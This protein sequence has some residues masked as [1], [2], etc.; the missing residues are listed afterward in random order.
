MTRENIT[1]APLNIHGQTNYYIN[2]ICQFWKKKHFLF[3]FVFSTK[4]SNISFQKNILEWK[5]TQGHKSKTGHLNHKH[6][7]QVERAD[8]LQS[9]GQGLV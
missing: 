8:F 3:F 6:F 7:S 5:T 4:L 1:C 9:K 2:V